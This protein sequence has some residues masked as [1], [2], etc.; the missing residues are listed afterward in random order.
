MLI[1]KSYWNT[2]HCM[3]VVVVR[4]FAVNTFYKI[5]HIQFLEQEN[6]ERREGLFYREQCM[7]IY[8]QYMTLFILCFCHFS[9]SAFIWEVEWA[10][11][12]WSVSGAGDGAPGSA[13]GPQ[14]PLAAQDRHTATHEH[15]H[16]V[17]QG[18][19][20]TENSVTSLI[21]SYLVLTGDW[22]QCDS[23]DE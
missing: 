8:E 11:E 22:H 4:L 7:T 9:V 6:I 13:G 3:Y 18:I 17:P 21:V 10:D 5:V 20:L 12:A 15:P 14:T 2:F 23:I 16:Q 1:V 19:I